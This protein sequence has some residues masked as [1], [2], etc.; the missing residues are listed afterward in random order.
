MPAEFPY[1]T[2]PANLRKF[3]EKIRTLGVPDKVSIA[4]LASLGFKSTNDRPII[5]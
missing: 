1:I 5:S 2:N 3:L 4:Y